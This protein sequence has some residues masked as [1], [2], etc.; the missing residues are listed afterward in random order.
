MVDI[1]SLVMHLLT[2][3]AAAA[4]LRGKGRYIAVCGADVIPA[5][6]TEPGHFRC[7]PCL[8]QSASV[9]SQRSR[10]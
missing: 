7:E 4:G 2:P 3:D 6:L 8:S 1:G 9:P 10:P 5:S